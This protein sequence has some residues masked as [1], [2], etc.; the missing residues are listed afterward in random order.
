MISRAIQVPSRGLA[1]TVFERANGGPLH[2]RSTGRRMAGRHYDS[3]KNGCAIRW[4]CRTELSAFYRAE[5]NADIT[6]YR[7]YPHRLE[8]VRHGRRHAYVPHLEL[9]HA[10]GLVEIQEVASRIPFEGLG[11]YAV[12]LSGAAEAYE[13]LGWH[14][15]IVDRGVVEGQPGFSA[16]ETI[17]SYRHTVVSAR[18]LAIIGDLHQR[19][20]IQTLGSVKAAYANPALGM[21]KA[22]AM[23]VQRILDIDLTDGLHD[24]AL[25]R[26]LVEDRHD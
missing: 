25:V 16:A 19:G 8:F 2:R 15:R 22:Y 26:I 12:V 6:G 17:Q 20:E 10:S 23:A 13:A 3:R 9:R 5:V 18:D 21:A 11:L 14:F 4:T 24:G 7:M 1:A